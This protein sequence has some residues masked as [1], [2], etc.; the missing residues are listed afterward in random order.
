MGVVDVRRTERLDLRRAVAAGELALQ[1]VWG[2]LGGHG[3][4]L[5]GQASSARCHGA[6][7][8]R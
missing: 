4:V 7:I 6:V 5:V 3:D 1:V 8:E 2:D